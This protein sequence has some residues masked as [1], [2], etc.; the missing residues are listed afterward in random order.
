MLRAKLGADWAGIPGERREEPLLGWPLGL[1]LALALMVPS[2]ASTE[3]GKA[4]R[5]VLPTA[6]TPKWE[7]FCHPKAGTE[8]QCGPISLMLIGQIII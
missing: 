8:R 4:S 5:I 3:E 2:S 1:R 6:Q 7:A